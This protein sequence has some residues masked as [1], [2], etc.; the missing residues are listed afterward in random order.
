MAVV[1]RDA[2]RQ[3]AARTDAVTVASGAG[4]GEARPG[5]VPLPRSVGGQGKV[6]VAQ[7]CPPGMCP[8]F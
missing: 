6:Y 8:S 7:R 4:G 2:I 3:G 1:P 5:V